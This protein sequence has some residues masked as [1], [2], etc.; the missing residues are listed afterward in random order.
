MG[1]LPV[2]VKWGFAIAALVGI[3]WPTP[4]TS[5]TADSGSTRPSETRIEDEQSTAQPSDSELINTLA[6]CVK[7]PSNVRLGVVFLLD[8]SQSL[9]SRDPD[10][11]RVEA[12]AQ[13]IEAMNKVIT[14]VDEAKKEFGS[15]P[16]EFTVD[17][18]IDGFGSSYYSGEWTELSGD[19]EPSTLLARADSFKSRTTDPLTDYRKAAEGALNSF[20]DYDATFG[21]QNCKLLFWFTDGQYDTD[22]SKIYG[23]TPYL[24]E[25]EVAE[26]LSQELCGSGGVVDQI[27]RMQVGVVGFGL[28]RVGGSADFSLLRSVVTNDEF[29][30][31]ARNQAPV[32]GSCGDERALGEFKTASVEELVNEFTDTLVCILI[33]CGEVVDP[34]YCEDVESGSQGKC[35]LVFM[36]SRAESGFNLWFKTSDVPNFSA[37]IKDPDGNSYPLGD[38]NQEL[39][40]GLRL[41]RVSNSWRWVSGNQIDFVSAENIW[42]GEWR[43]EFNGLRKDDPL[44]VIGFFWNDLEILPVSTSPLISRD[45]GATFDSLKFKVTSNGLPFNESADGLPV[46]TGLLDVRFEALD[47]SGKTIAESREA[48]S[49]WD[50]IS[51]PARFIEQLV[52]GDSAPWETNAGFTIRATPIAVTFE[53]ARIFNEYESES[54][55]FWFQDE[56][57]LVP[58]SIPDVYDRS[59]TESNIDAHATTFAIHFGDSSLI[60]SNVDVA[61]SARATVGDETRSFVVEVNDESVFVIPSDVFAELLQPPSAERAGNQFIPGG[62]LKYEFDVLLN[63]I[64]I[65]KISDPQRVKSL[66]YTVGVRSGVGYPAIG[67]LPDYEVF[68][69]NPV[70]LKVP[71]IPPLEG[72]GSVELVSAQLL[73]SQGNQEYFVAGDRTCKVSLGDDLCVFSLGHNF[74]WRD[75]VDVMLTFELSGSAV[76][77]GENYS[78]DERTISVS[79]TRPANP[80]SGFVT[81]FLLLMV[82]VLVQLSLRAIWVSL[83]ARFEGAGATDGSWRLVTLNIPFAA[84][85]GDLTLSAQSIIDAREHALFDQWIQDGGTNLSVGMVDLSRGWLDS[86]LGFRRNTKAGLGEN[87][88]TSMRGGATWVLGARLIDNDVFSNDGV[89]VLSDGS[90]VGVPSRNLADLWVLTVPSETIAGDVTA[91][92]HIVVDV[93]EK[94]DDMRRTLSVRIESIRSVVKREV[95]N[96]RDLRTAEQ[97]E[98]E[99]L[100]QEKPSGVNGKY[101]LT[102]GVHNEDPP[103]EAREWDLGGPSDLVEEVPAAIGSDDEIQNFDGKRV[104][105]WQR[106]SGKARG[107]ENLEVVNDPNDPDRTD[108]SL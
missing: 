24:D 11:A 13:A 16:R 32:A 92:I 95:A 72:V 81:A 85:T 27:R 84:A 77:D 75:P 60:D 50:N 39:A 102:Q 70:D 103:A 64:G 53:T 33:G 54:F 90:I 35:E 36:L 80:L 20:N 34:E 69:K 73:N 8:T 55:S 94:L 108:W 87:L 23:N 22:D 71:I 7:E 6:E 29:N 4:T 31:S 30:L 78:I 28:N 52:D 5:A 43:V 38:S 66:S 48:Y 82:F 105:W 61:I 101:D 96:I 51:P 67:Q 40:P 58:A 88:R 104:R 3:A 57:S 21:T 63:W 2:R 86:F 68:G 45:N 9:K 19:T 49:Q 18:K 65:P 76:D 12:T 44:P 41:S 93:G 15:E 17:V 107:S 14:R 37:E 89:A 42:A 59:Q 1:C 26:I 25:D 79:M 83:S 99:I 74:Q 46:A 106:F 62:S 47:D 97:L 10:N 98:G 56:I 91:T 100:P